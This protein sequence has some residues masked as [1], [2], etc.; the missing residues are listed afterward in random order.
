MNIKDIEKLAALSR[1]ALSEEEKNS[2]LKDMDSILNYVDQVKEAVAISVENAGEK[3]YSRNIWREDGKPHES[4]IFTETLL[5]SAPA[6]HGQY[7][8]VKKIL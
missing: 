3:P 8:K 4:G 7:I 5:S 1:I 2:L 6:R